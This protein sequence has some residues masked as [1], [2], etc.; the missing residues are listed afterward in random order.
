MK[1]KE[2]SIKNFRNFKDIKINI[3]NKNIFFGL[4]DIGKT[5][6]MYALRYMFDKNIRK[7]GFLEFD[8]HK[9]NVETPIEITVVI[10]ISDTDNPDSQK[11]RAR[12][13]GDILSQHSNVFIRL[14]AKYNVQELIAMPIMYWGGDLDRLYEI[15]QRG[16]RYDIDYIFN[17]ISDCRQ[18]WQRVIHTRCHIFAL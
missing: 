3:S 8:F 11:L 12:L 14:V 4:N 17:V 18:I 13:K 2:V 1:F 5:N 10:D 15:K 16:Y 9:K 7:N 6:F